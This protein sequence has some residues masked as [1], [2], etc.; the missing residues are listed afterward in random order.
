LILIFFSIWPLF[1]DLCGILQPTARFSG[2]KLAIYLLFAVSLLVMLLSRRFHVDYLFIWVLFFCCIAIGLYKCNFSSAFLDLLVCL[3]G[4]L[5]CVFLRNYNIS[6]RVILKCVYICGAIVAVSVIINAV[7]GGYP[8]WMRSLYTDAAWEQMDQKTNSFKGS[9]SGILAYPGS[10]ACFLVSG[11]AAYYCL[12]NQPTKKGL[13]KWIVLFAFALAIILTQKRSFMLFVPFSVFAVWL[14][15]KELS[16][17]SAVK[18]KKLLKSLMLVVSGIVICILLYS[19]VP[20]IKEQVD[21]LIGRFTSGEATLS[22]RTYLYALAW[23]LFE[24]HPITGIGWGQY[25][26]HTLGLL[27]FYD[28]TTYQTHNVYLQLL[29]ETGIVGLFGFLA[30][31]LTTL[32]H[33]IKKYRKHLTQWTVSEKAALQFSLY[34]QVLFLAYAMSG[35]NLYDHNFLIMYF[36]GILISFCPKGGKKR[37]EDRDHDISSSEQLRSRTAGVRSA[38]VYNRFERRL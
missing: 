37:S 9:F 10:A 21:S 12:S 25:R 24:S 6:D 5:L 14:F 2:S 4:F 22:G 3:S 23:D 15:G 32:F 19:Y 30:A 17:Q 31:T 34:Q 8:G 16:V 13:R 27:N 18:I 26:Q 38:E 1:W 7:M 20:F 36:I 11:I 35:N 29:C 33:T 28:D